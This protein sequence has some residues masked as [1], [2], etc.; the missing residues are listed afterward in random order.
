[1]KT[2][3]PLYDRAIHPYL[4]MW[5]VKKGK[6]PGDIANELGIAPSTLN[7]WRRAY[8]EF[9][10]SLGGGAELFDTIVE[11]SLLK[12][13][14]GYSYDEVTYE[15]TKEGDGDFE[16]TPVKSVRKHV[17]PELSAILA[18]L[19]NRK[20]KVWGDSRDNNDDR[21]AYF[22]EGLREPDED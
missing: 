4:A 3:E 9:E 11:A 19:K 1:M 20:P 16:M 21:I 5:L 12:R 6:T 2:N 13:A 18:W 8:P 10:Q 17:Q 7:R 15:W 14:C 22:L